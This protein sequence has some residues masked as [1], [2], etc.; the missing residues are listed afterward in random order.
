MESRTL[1]GE[2]LGG[3]DLEDEEALRGQIAYWWIRVLVG[4]LNRGRVL[5]VYTPPTHTYK[6]IYTYTYT[7]NA[8]SSRH[9]VRSFGGGG[10]KASKSYVDT[11]VA[12]SCWF[13][14][15]C[16]L[17]FVSIFVQGGCGLDGGCVI[18]M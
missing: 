1:G 4:V 12:L 11:P 7:F 10:G 18:C 13:L 9:S 16:D 14:G 5:L 3:L 8:P 6:S 15:I 2:V 17:F